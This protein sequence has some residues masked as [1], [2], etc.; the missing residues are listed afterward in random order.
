MHIKTFFAVAALIGS[1]LAF[2]QDYPNRPVTLVVPAGPGGGTDILARSVA[3]EF[4]QRL[5]Q[6]FIVENKSGASG[7]IGTQ[8]VVRA[9]PDGYTLLLTYSAPIYYAPHILKN[10]PYDV[11][12]DLEVISEIAETSYMLV[13]NDDVPVTN[14]KEFMAWAEQDKGKLNYGSLGTGSAGH[15]ASAYLNSAYNLEMTH[16]PYKSEAPFAQDLAAGIVPWG[17]G[18]LAPMSP[19]IQSGRVRA[20]AVLADERLSSL[21]DVPTMKEEGF[22]EPELRSMAWFTLAAPAETPQPILDLLEKHAQEIMQSTS[23]QE[24]LEFLGLDAVGSSAAA[25]LENY[26]TSYPVI[27]KLVDISGA[28]E[29]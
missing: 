15:L 2:A 11:K 9:K 21:P 17:M 18:T 20:I 4:S 8:S 16:V 23:L 12:D 27:E 28:R 29:P 10:V 6:P 24:R 14:M 13:V 25:F 26:D 1:S 19:H 7:V 5:G 22:T 3:E